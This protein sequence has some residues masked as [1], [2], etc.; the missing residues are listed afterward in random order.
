M[1][2]L[3]EK[4]WKRF[5]R[6]VADMPVGKKLFVGFMC[7][8]A[9]L[10]LVVGALFLTVSRLG[11][12]NHA[13]VD[14]AAKRSEY[15]DELRFAAADLRAEQQAY[16]IDGTGSR[17]SYNAAASRFESALEQLRGA[18]HGPVEQSLVRKI[19]TGYETFLHTDQMIF[20]AVQMG[21]DYLARNLTLGAESLD[22]GFM[23]AD[24]ASV[25][26]LADAERADAI[27]QFQ[28]TSRDARDLGIVLSALA[29]MVMFVASWLITRLIRDPLQRVQIAAERAAEGDLDAEAEVDS[30]DETGRLARAFNRMLAKLQTREAMLLADHHRQ[31]TQSR[32]HRALEMADDESAA[33]EVL[34][35][36][37]DDLLDGRSA[38]LLLADNSKANLEQ[39][40]VAGA[41]PDGPGCPVASPYSCVAV[42]SGAAVT[43]PSSSALDACPHLR[44]R[45]GDPCSAVCVPVSFMGRAM[46]VI[47]TIA[48]EGHV[49]ET[50]EV[51]ALSNL[52]TQAG[53]RIGML[54]TMVRTS[55]QASTD[56]LTGLMN[57][58]TFQSRMRAMRRSGVAFAMVMADIDH[59]KRL[60][61]THGHETGDRAL[62][63][64]CEVAASTLRSTDLFARWGGEE[65]AFAL[66]G[67]SAEDA[68]EVL[69]RVRLELAAKLSTSDLPGFTVSYGIIAADHCATLDDAVRRADDALYEAKGAGRDRCVIARTDGP[70]TMTDVGDPTQS[71]RVR[72]P[73]FAVPSGVLA[74]LA[75]DDDP[76]EM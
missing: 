44:N 32:I 72:E 2:T 39:A 33:L 13:I 36:T 15:A 52:S 75:H 6:F 54:R 4:Y 29:L 27:A 17:T 74:R 46:G 62:K 11:E 50:S 5:R 76:M 51:D 61:D 60:N 64:F 25:T 43:F 14:I 22:L 56:G 35:R 8:T 28:T 48:E 69:D 57:R 45:G 63:T 18:A 42:R 41:N 49:A 9:V 7:L 40:V 66:V 1:G 23:A 67:L 21:D 24:A 31:E 70:T 68:A 38:E 19:T 20:D 26:E 12:A 30:D 53:A 65:F 73:A 37:L 59:F 58:R 3:T 10:G 47:H 16:V 71:T 34:G 55:L